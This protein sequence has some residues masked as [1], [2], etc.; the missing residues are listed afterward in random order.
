[1]RSSRQRSPRMPRA[2]VPSIRF[3]STL[4]AWNTRWAC[5]TCTR[6]TPT[7]WAGLASVRSSPRKSTLPP[8]LGISADTACSVLLLPAPLRPRSTTNSPA[9]TSKDTPCTTCALPEPTTRS[10][11][12]RMVSPQR[13]CAALSGPWAAGSRMAS[14]SEVDAHHIFIGAHPVGR[15]ADDDAAEVD[16]RDPGADPEHEVGVVFHQQHADAAVLQGRQHCAKAVDLVAAQAAGRLVQQHEARSRRQ[17]ARD[18]QEALLAMP[19]HIGA[20]VECMGQ[21]H[22]AEQFERALRQQL[23][24]GPCARRREHGADHAGARIAPAAEHHVFERA[25][26]RQQAR[27]LEGARDAGAGAALHGSPRQVF[28]AE[29]DAALVDRVVAAEHVQQGRRAA[30]VRPDQAL[31][32]ARS[33]FDRYAGQ[34]GDAAEVLAQAAHGQRAGR[35]LR[36]HGAGSGCDMAA[37]NRGRSGATG[38]A[39]RRTRWRSTQAASA[40][41]MP[42]GMSSTAVSSSTLYS[43]LPSFANG[44][45]ISGSSVST[46]VPAKGPMMLPRP[47]MVMQMKKNMPNSNAKDSGD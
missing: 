16:G 11:T 35:G 7:M 45:A 38:G 22:A 40:L 12:R 10:R 39:W 33:Q 4:S 13:P 21:A 3:C 14:G 19:E 44:A 8:R 41:P 6:P 32:L 26:G 27:R 37:V 9:C 15:V 23:V 29:V 20:F 43:R 34:R 17:G 46:T 47:P 18:F 2:Q 31:D 1:M 36:R 25:Q 42:L 30:A 24:L 28:V 5:S